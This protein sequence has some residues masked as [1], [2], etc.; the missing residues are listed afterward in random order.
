MNLVQNSFA[1]LEISYTNLMHNYNY[2]RSILKSSTKLLI[3]IKANSYG[4]GAIEFAHAMEK[5]GADYF[6]V[7][8]AVEGVEL[9]HEGIIKTPIIILTAGTDYFKEIVNNNLEPAIPNIE[10]LILFD[11]YLKDNDIKEYPIHLTIDTGMHRLGFMEKDFNPLLDFLKSTQRIK[12]KSILSHLASA[13]EPQHDKFT[14]EQIELYIK[15]YNKIILILGYSPLKHILNSAGIERFPQYQ[16]D[17]VRLGIG[18]YG[19]SAIDESLLKPAAS[20]KCN[21][22]QIK[23]LIPSDGTVGYGRHG[24]ITGNMAIATLPLGYADGINR[25]LGCGHAKFLLNGKLVPTIGNICMDTFMIDIT[26]VDAQIGDT[27]TIFGENPTANELA[28]I[29]DTIPYEIFASVSRRVKRIVC[30]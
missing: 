26:G 1:Q 12:V 5:A 16:F 3:L 20:L 8:Y 11:N 24:K 21:I 19:I 28:K 29:L 2:F 23:T 22:L 18:I 13:D 7:A 14:I 15:L 9:R 17:M 6:A 25:H 4:H 27:V 30:Q 10:T